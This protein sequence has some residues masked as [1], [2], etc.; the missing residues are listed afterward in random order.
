MKTLTAALLLAYAGCIDGNDD[1]KDADRTPAGYH[2]VYHDTGLLGSGLMTYGQI[3]GA[4]DAAYLRSA[5]DLETRYGIDR[6]RTLALPFEEKI[7]F[8]LHD[9]FRFVATDGKTWATG[10]YT[11]GTIAVAMHPKSHVE[12]GIATPSDA[13]PWTL[14]TGSITGRTYFGRLDLVAAFPALEHE[15]GHHFF[16]PRFEH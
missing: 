12:S 11:G 2:V 8:A 4:F 5:I 15:L 7:L 9:H 1:Y 3:L 14:V 10:E 16:G 13:L 6:Q